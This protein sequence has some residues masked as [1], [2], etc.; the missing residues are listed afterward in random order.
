L[1]SGGQ[2]YG[3]FLNALPG[4]I[5]HKMLSKVKK[6]HILP[7]FEDCLDTLLNIHHSHGVFLMGSMRI[8]PFLDDPKYCSIV[9]LPS[10]Y[11]P[12]SI[13][14]ALA[15]DSDFSGLFRFFI[16]KATENG[17]IDK[18]LK[19]AFPEPIGDI[20]KNRCSVDK[21]VHFGY[22]KLITPFTALCSGTVISI[23]LGFVERLYNLCQKNH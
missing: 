5:E 19:E 9:E 23:L 21:T 16:L 10:A 14:I 8:R 12:I 22:G 18:W 1:K 6:E 20:Y 7:T 17:L 2:I 4:T 3:S 15:K 11:K 13:G